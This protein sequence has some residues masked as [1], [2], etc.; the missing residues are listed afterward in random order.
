MTMFEVHKA[1]WQALKDK[2][3]KDKLQHIVT[4][5]GVTIVICLCVL[6]V[7]VGW[8]V[9]A[10]NQKEPA[11]MGY[12]LNG[13]VKSE[14]GSTLEQEILQRLELDEKE[15]TARLVSD[16]YFYAAQED[17]EAFYVLESMAA[18]IGANMLDFVATDK[19]TFP[20][21]SAYYADLRTVFTAEQLETYA[22]LLVYVEET[23]LQALTEGTSEVVVFPKYHRDPGELKEPV[24]VG[25]ALPADCRLLED[26]KYL[27][28]E[29]YFGFIVNS[30]R[31]EQTIAFLELI[32]E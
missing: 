11:L 13:S 21:L 29:V 25:L 18:Q 27:G 24:P 26:Y 20:V 8:I 1:Q 9:S 10:V 2:P 32:L 16:V 6:G 17:P 3:L 15:Y 30:E 22:D 14:S 5:Y 19:E 31:W 7:A 23:E 4:Y 28:D 12:L